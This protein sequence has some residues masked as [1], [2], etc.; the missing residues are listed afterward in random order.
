VT[1]LVTG[2][3]G[4][5]G[6][7]VVAALEARG[8]SVVGAGHGCERSVELRIAA[9]VEE[10]VAE[11]RPRVVYHLGG[12]SSAVEMARDPTGGHPN[13]VQPAVNVFEAVASTGGGRVVIVSPC[14]VY[15]RPGRLPI[16]ETAPLVP[17]EVYAATRAA[18]EYM[19]RSYRDRGVEVVVA[20]VFWLAG[21]GVDRRAPLGD[22]AARAARGETVRLADANLRRDVLDVRDAAEGIVLLGE[23]GVAGEAYNLCS[24]AA[25]SLREL[26]EIV[27]GGPVEVDPAPSRA[28]AVY[29]G[30]PAKAEALG[31]R[32]AVPLE[33]ALREMA[34]WA[35]RAG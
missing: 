25:R 6:R 19:A 34:E 31:W 24:G 23:R 30:S 17:S 12:T 32:R 8:A 15:G 9:H 4:L 26:A 21:P 14:E 27:V 5:L 28:A 33:D 2:A 22:V 35:R 18:V 10:L 20:R 11:V 1:A 13:V 3:A 7:R 16:E 29:L